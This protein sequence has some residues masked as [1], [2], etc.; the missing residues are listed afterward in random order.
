MLNPDLFTTY[1]IS[2]GFAIAALAVT[3][4]AMSLYY[5]DEKS[6]GAS[7]SLAKEFGRACVHIK[8]S[9]YRIQGSGLLDRVESVTLDVRP[10]L[11]RCSVGGTN[12]DIHRAQ[13]RVRT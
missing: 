9:C 10:L 6:P 13:I 12:V 2:A 7:T 8:R 1:L 5:K 11:N 4:A 3:I